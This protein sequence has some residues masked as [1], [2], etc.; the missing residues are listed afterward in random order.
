[1]KINSTCG[2]AISNAA[3]LTVVVGSFSLSNNNSISIPCGTDSAKVTLSSSVT[4]TFTTP[5]NLVAS[6]LPNGTSASFTV[7][8]MTPGNSSTVAMVNSDSLAAGSYNFTVTGT[9]NAIAQST[10][11][12]VTITAAPP[13]PLMIADQP[14]DVVVDLGENATFTTGYRKNVTSYQWQDSTSTRAS[15]QNITGANTASYTKTNMDEASNGNAYRVIINTNCG[16]LTSRAAL[17]SLPAFQIQPNPNR[18]SFDVSVEVPDA[19][20][21]MRRVSALLV[22][23]NRGS[24]IFEK[25]VNDPTARKIHCEL[26]N[27]STGIYR[28]VMLDSNGA[29]IQKIPVLI[30][31]NMN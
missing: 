27:I 5:I 19:N 29:V 21:V 6:N 8:P 26:S 7:N 3:R 17:L 20:K 31:P 15:W 18:G 25:K 10:A 9:A 22:Y 12:N 14:S 1:V 28:I 30:N 2:T 16:I 24:K 13:L 23:D 11:I 4:G